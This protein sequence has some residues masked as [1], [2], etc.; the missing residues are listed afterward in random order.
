MF[1]GLNKTKD[2]NNAVDFY[3]IRWFFS[4]RAYL[5][6][7]VVFFLSIILILIFGIFPSFKKAI[8]INK[9]IKEIE[10]ENKKLADKVQ[11]FKTYNL[12]PDYKI[13]KK[14]DEILYS[15][16]PIMELMSV[17][18]YVSGQEDSLVAIEKF[19]ISPGLVSTDSA[20]LKENE[21]EKESKR[22][23]EDFILFALDVFGEKENVSNYFKKLENLSPLMTVS[24]LQ[25]TQ[26]DEE[27]VN[28][29]AEILL[30]FYNPQQNL[31]LAAP[32]PKDIMIDKEAIIALMN[33][34]D[35]LEIDL[36]QEG[37]VGG[38]EN[39]FESPLQ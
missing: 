29:Q 34:I 26:R 23:K 19:D 4:V 28:G 2:K 36:T 15:V 22:K 32:L 31:E 24:N 38:K 9:Q 21:D 17:Y 33:K 30:H 12:T 13:L 37:L 5:F 14:S 18:R 1:T 16:K 3:S 10:I 25:I 35:K 20:S 39:P 6:W 7:T 11:S 8:S 27:L